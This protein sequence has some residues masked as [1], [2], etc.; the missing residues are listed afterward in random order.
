M[1]GKENFCLTGEPN[2]RML[3]LGYIYQ[4]IL[5]NLE[6]QSLGYQSVVMDICDYFL[7][8]LLRDNIYKINWVYMRETNKVHTFSQ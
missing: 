3:T 5:N 1:S 4:L 6:I 2:P 7:W 8:G